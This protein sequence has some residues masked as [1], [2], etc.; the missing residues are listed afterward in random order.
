MRNRL[1]LLSI[2]FCCLCLQTMGQISTNDSDCSSVKGYDITITNANLP[3]DTF[4]LTGNRGCDIFIL[5]QATPKKGVL[6]FKN[7]RSEIPCGIYTISRQVS[8]QFSLG[9]PD[10]CLNVVINLSNKMQARWNGKGYTIDNN[11]ESAILY[12]FTKRW[13]TTSAACDPDELSKLV[14]EY[15]VPSPKSFISKYIMS[16]AGWFANN[17][18]R[19]LSCHDA[20][21]DLPYTDLS[22]SR[23]FYAPCDLYYFI[24]NFSNC[25]IYDTDSTIAFVDSV[26]NHCTSPVLRNYFTGYFFG[27]LDQHIPDYDPVLVHL[28]DQYDRGWIEEGYENRFKRKVDNLRK[29]I[30]GAKIPMLISHD[31]DGKAHSTNEVE[32]KYTVL[33]FWDPDCDHCQEYTPILHQ[34]YQEHAEDWDFEVFAVEI[35]NDHDRWI[36][37]SDINELWDWTNLSTSMG[38]ANLDF[39]EYFDIMTTPVMFLIDNSQ[40]HTII[41]RQIT[42][43]ELRDFLSTER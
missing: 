15:V 40:D 25:D 32:S 29:I 24:P 35:N 8:N 31:A 42:L 21:K 4:Y 3:N 39:I 36:T 17:E 26:L 7:K 12:A 1:L 30:P 11:P 22:D 2:L 38:E 16:H 28:Y 6:R 5:G 20:L 23:M 10:T 13:A 33:W 34:M 14:D 18:T 27:L 9:N 43:N 37:F 19:I 41:K